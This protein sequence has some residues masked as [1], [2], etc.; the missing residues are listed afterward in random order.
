MA[1]QVL[2]ADLRIGLTQFDA[3][4]K[5]AIAAA[6]SASEEISKAFDKVGTNVRSL[7]TEVKKLNDS[8]KKTADA[9]EKAAAASQKQ[10]TAL[11]TLKGALGALG[12]H[13]TAQQM[14]QFAL[15]TVKAAEALAS[16]EQQFT[17]LTG[18]QKAA[19]EEMAFIRAETDRLALS[20][21]EGAKGYARLANA[22]KGTKLEGEGVR[23]VFIGLN[24]VTRA[25]RLSQ[26]EYG[27]VLNQVTQII[28][29]GKIQ[30]EELMTLAESGIPIY[31]MLA[32]SMG[33]SAETLSDMLQKGKVSSQALIL[34]VGEIQKKYDELAEQAAN[35]IPAQIERGWNKIL[36]ETTDVVQGILKSGELLRAFKFDGNNFDIFPD[37]E[38]VTANVD[39]I[40]R[41]FL[42][43]DLIIREVWKRAGQGIVEF[44]ET[45]RE[46][47]AALNEFMQNIP[48]MK[49]AQ[50]QFKA[51]TGSLDQ[52]AEKTDKT[53]TAM[54]KTKDFFTAIFGGD[55]QAAIRAWNGLVSEGLEKFG[56]EMPP[57]IDSEKMAAD[58]QKANEEL[59]KLQEQAKKD[60]ARV[61]DKAR[62]DKFA[63]DIESE[64]AALDEI[65]KL[66]EDA[67]RAQAQ[68]DRK[69]ASDMA[70]IASNI[71]TRL[72]EDA[73]KVEQMVEEFEN[74]GV[75]TKGVLNLEWEINEKAK[76]DLNKT[77][78]DMKKNVRESM[79]T[80]ISDAIKGD[81]DN[82]QDAAEL[83][84]GIF[85]DVF[86]NIA[87]EVI[88]KNVMDPLLDK[89]KGLLAKMKGI[90]TGQGG[91]SGGGVAS[92]QGFLGSNMSGGQ[93]AGNA[94]GAIGAG[95]G[96]G[97]GVSN[98]AGGGKTGGAL[99][100]VA[101]GAMAGAMIGLAFGGVG[102]IIGA[103]A[104][105]IVG[106][107][108]GYL[109]AKDPV[110]TSLRM[111][112]TAGEPVSS[113]NGARNISPFG[114]ISLFEGSKASQEVSQ[115]ATLAISEIDSG[116]AKM[117]DSRQREIVQN[118][119]RSAVPEGLQVESKDVGDAIAKGI[120]QRLYHALTAL[121][122]EG[123]AKNVVGELYTATSEN[124]QGI[125]ARAMEALD[126]L[127]TISDFKAGD[128]SQT[129]QQI[130]SINEEFQNLT[131]RATVLGL[132]TEEIAAEQQRQLTKIT[133]DF[134]QDISDAILG[135]TDPVKLEFEQLERMQAERRQNA[136]DAGADLAQ[137]DKLDKLEREELEKR[138]QENL[139]TITEAGQKQREAAIANIFQAIYAIEDPLKAALLSVQQQVAVFQAQVDQGLIPQS[140]VDRYEASA[141]DKV[142]EDERRRKEEE[143]QAVED[144]NQDIYNS[145]LGL[146]DANAA[147]LAEMDRMHAERYQKA[148]EMGADLNAVA[149]LNHSERLAKEKE[150]QD[151]LTAA[152]EQ[153]QQQ[154]EDALG[155][156]FMMI[157]QIEDPFRAVMLSI[158]QQLAQLQAQVDQG[159]IPQSLVDRWYAAA[160]SDALEK[161]RKR[162]ADEAQMVEDFNQD[163]YNSILGMTDASAAEL[164]QLDRDNQERL[165]RAIA[166]G[167]DIAAVE[168]YNN[169]LR[170]D[171]LQEHEDRKTAAIEQGQR[172]QENATNNILRAI[173]G[174][175]DPFQ[176]ALL[177]VQMQVAQFQAQV[178]Q[179][180]IP[181][182]LV[183]RY[184]E[185][186]T[187]QV[188]QQE[189]D[190]KA[191]EAEQR[192]REA[193]RLAE[194]KRREAEQRRREAE[195]RREQ[196]RREAEQRKREAQQRAEQKKR[197]AEQRKREAEQKKREQEQEAERRRQA[198]LQFNAALWGFTDPFKVSMQE[199]N[200]QVREF[201]QMT[202]DGI[203]PKYAVDMFERLAI[204][205]LEV[206][207]AVQ[208]LSGGSG[209]PI[210]QIGEAFEDFIRAG[211]PQSQAAEELATLQERFSG[212]VESAKILGLETAALE[213]SYTQQAKAI[214]EKAIDAINKEMDAKKEQLKQIDDFLASMRISDVLPER[215][216][217]G[218]SRKQ[219][220]QALGSGDVQKAV[221]AA[222]E[223][224]NIAQEQFGSTSQ[225]FAARNEVERLL[226]NMQ[227]QQA[228]NIEAEREK[229]ILREER[230]LEQVQISRTSVDFL[231]RISTD[232]SATSRGII[233]LI[234]IAKT[235]SEEAVQTRQLLLRL[236]AKIKA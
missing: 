217:L 137:L 136:I 110:K 34:L 113:E 222:Q 78:E 64:S 16:I 74:T 193:E 76:Q 206:D 59:L 154:R 202:K 44:F 81:L 215:M 174:I 194:Q 165:D 45:A 7:P 226:T 167:G 187:A 117:L 19:K 152:Q 213:W 141:T 230:E 177:D 158:E 27:R 196:K 144:F 94:G 162:R 100:G 207:R 71:S 186:A 66:H 181:Q 197:E 223:Y 172:D 173:Y 139:T 54:G 234:G 96:V 138:H 23:Q 147:E 2:V 14:V 40:M 188:Y 17:L 118:Y 171:L 33:V 176:A 129:A 191:R 35:T 150:H 132:P 224:L 153:G 164:A 168:Q 123:V 146:K 161:E 145:I 57:P 108:M 175:T 166:I 32:K 5:K 49:W 116:I 31:T 121:E 107:V 112:T 134:N 182:S 210:E 38:V 179:G 29:K 156:V 63:K 211:S 13:V 135:I 219:F 67:R 185:V 1:E 87:S 195:Q 95:V 50:E 104:G 124:I 99:G 184:N 69:V 115:A 140:L 68:L 84:K 189:R 89:F 88:A 65:L 142:W 73:A 131:D 105:A 201:R 15:N 227:E 43:I 235:Q 125:Q 170:E 183:D 77:I 233:Q 109:A 155:N 9:S 11:S 10:S 60:L 61:D 143:A 12:L 157:W 75:P 21:L 102:A 48:G 178:D 37:K 62:D 180:L 3:D 218:E 120:Q 106:G 93:F 26:E 53:K 58:A 24:T 86:A 111:Q 204:A 199:I 169:M 82:I 20:T 114:V 198:K 151:E 28:A 92:G 36:Q 90:A 231:R 52:V 83:I 190:R 126:I 25:L 212:L 91:T 209:S 18:S 56:Q 101:G 203:V 159:L 149:E 85:A 214:R 130:K 133:K 160:T 42:A 127:A 225:F 8:L 229:L 221:S 128:L 236:A 51:I 6:E 216:R 47:L 200:E 119:F 228:R 22:A 122:G 41:Q 30:T 98:M 205:S 79:A 4:L 192:K 55:G 232:N 148:M 208:A 220:G 80:T 103:A 39:F 46:K 70:D 163:I 72:S 97:M